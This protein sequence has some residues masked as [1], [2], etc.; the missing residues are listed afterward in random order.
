MFC[1]CL[2]SGLSWW[3]SRWVG[4]KRLFYVNLL[5]DTMGESTVF[6]SC[7]SGTS[8]FFFLCWH[9]V[10]FAFLKK[11]KV[12]IFFCQSDLFLL[13]S[14]HS[15]FNFSFFWDFA[16]LVFLIYAL[17]VVARGGGFVL[18]SPKTLRLQFAG[19]W[20]RFSIFFT[21]F[22]RNVKRANGKHPC[23]PPPPTPSMLG[24][25]FPRFWL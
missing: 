11:T 5:W 25:R 23:S 10:F 1:G 22:R 7:S 17:F 16:K 6:C 21:G 13:I 3:F 14:Q 19:W 15:F 18:L 4:I 2:C 24:R 8:L 20:F 9:A 12:Y